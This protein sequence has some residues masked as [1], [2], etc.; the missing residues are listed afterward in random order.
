M[1]YIKIIQLLKAKSN[2]AERVVY[3]VFKV[4]NPFVSIVYLIKY[5]STKAK[6]YS[7]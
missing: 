6:K 5:F 4:N 2:E 1:V 3:P 7:E